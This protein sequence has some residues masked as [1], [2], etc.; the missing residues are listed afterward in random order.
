LQTLLV[1]IRT[2]LVALVGIVMILQWL[3]LLGAS[4][5]ACAQGINSSLR[6]TTTSKHRKN[7][8]TTHNDSSSI[9]VQTRVIGG[10]NAAPGQFP[11]YVQADSLGFGCGGSLIWYDIV[12]TAAHCLPAYQ[13]TV[14]VGAY[15]SNST[16]YGAR[17]YR[18]KKNI[19][20][21]DFNPYLKIPDFMIVWLEEK[22]DNIKQSQLGRLNSLLKIP[23][24]RTKMTL[25][26]MGYT[27]PSDQFGSDYLNVAYNLHAV[28]PCHVSQY[29]ICAL[30]KNIDSCYGDSGGPLMDSTDLRIV[31]IVSSGLSNDCNSGA[32]GTYSNVASEFQWLR[33]QLCKYSRSP[34]LATCANARRIANS[35]GKQTPVPPHACRDSS[36]TFDVG[37]HFAH[38][39]CTWLVKNRFYKHQDLC[40]YLHIAAR[41]PRT[42]SS[43]DNVLD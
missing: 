11:F 30:G 22:V 43:C 28:I 36:Y 1:I 27:H 2:S 20:H 8:L 31:G 5:F 32:P 34:P 26:G 38:K 15:Q 19:Q 42:C 16:A 23:N 39:S 17:R 12:L 35:T 10:F 40:Q 3:A 4:T 18:V 37:N 9:G 13:S 33:V 41:C 6:F 24:N 7:N 21:P 29:L 14:L 25:I